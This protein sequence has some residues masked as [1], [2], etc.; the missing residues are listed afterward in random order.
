MYCAWI[1]DFRFIQQYNDR[2]LRSFT[3][4]TTS[5]EHC[6]LLGRWH[7]SANQIAAS[8][9]GHPGDTSGGRE[10]QKGCSYQERQ[11][12]RLGGTKSI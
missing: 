12:T 8:K 5:T 6:I 1:S 2:I 9:S 11:A 4:Q 3:S 10:D 7:K